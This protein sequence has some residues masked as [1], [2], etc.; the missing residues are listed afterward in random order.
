[1]RY[2]YSTTATRHAGLVALVMSLVACG[3]PCLTRDVTDNFPV[4]PDASSPTCAV[5]CQ[6]GVRN[7]NA[8]GLLTAAGACFYCGGDGGPCSANLAYASPD[9]GAAVICNGFGFPL[10]SPAPGPCSS[11]CMAIALDGGIIVSL[12]SEDPA[13]PPT[14]CRFSSLPD[15]AGMGVTCDW[16]IPITYCSG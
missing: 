3:P 7:A 10:A 6:I 4:S 8:Q 9:G 16:K 1:M 5:A 12:G 15:S 2:P 11:L 13:G 14:D